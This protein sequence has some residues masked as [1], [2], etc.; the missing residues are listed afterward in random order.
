LEVFS[1]VSSNMGSFPVICGGWNDSG[2]VMQCHRLESGKWQHFA[3][4]IQGYIRL[5]LILYIDD[6]FD[7]FALFHSLSKFIFTS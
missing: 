7:I 5:A 3:N 2:L 6:I 1:A 4:L